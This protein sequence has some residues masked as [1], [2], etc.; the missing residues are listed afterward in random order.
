MPDDTL[1]DTSITIALADLTRAIDELEAE[2]PGCETAAD[3]AGLITCLADAEWRLH[4]LRRKVTDD[5]P[6]ELEHDVYDLLGH[7]DEE[8]F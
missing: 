5:C 4:G 1:D 2:A 7:D 8:D 3:I 6:P